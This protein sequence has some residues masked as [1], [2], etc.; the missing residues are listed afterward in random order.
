MP[1][2]DLAERRACQRRSD[3][4]HRDKRAA[5]VRS[6][7]ASINARTR[8]LK[9]ERR[10]HLDALKRERGCAD[11]GTRAGLIFDHRPGTVKLFN[12]S[13]GLTRS[14]AALMAEVAKCDVRCTA[15]HARRHHRESV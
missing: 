5:W 1:Y 2:A 10:A 11:C 4:R 13:K 7:R 9:A 3:A 14:E 6:N 15:C 12:P 8:A